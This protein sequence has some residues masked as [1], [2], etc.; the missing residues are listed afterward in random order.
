[1]SILLT[2][3]RINELFSIFVTQAKGAAATGKTDFNKVME[4]VL[5]PLFEIVYGC[6]NLKNLNVEKINYPGIDLG[7]EKARIAFQIT[8]TAD[9]EKVKDTLKKF[10]KYELYKKY[11]RLIIYIITEKQKISSD[12]AIKEIIGDKFSFDKEKDVID[13][14]D[15]LKKV[16]AFQ[17]DKTRKIENILEANFGSNAVPI[18]DNN[19]DEQTETV[20]LNL[21]PIIYPEHIYSGE[22]LTEVLKE[23]G[24]ID[25]S[26]LPWE[27]EGKSS[28]EKIWNFMKANGYKFASDWEYYDG[29]IYTF[30][31]LQTESHP[32]FSVLDVGTIEEST[33]E[34]FISLDN[35]YENI[36]KSLLRRCLQRM[37]Y[38]KGVTWQ[39]LENIFI[40]VEENN[41]AKR[42]EQWK[43]KKKNEREV[44]VRIM[45]NNKPK[46]I[47]KCKHF[48][49]HARFYKYSKEWYL[50]ITPDWFFSYDGFNKSLFAEKDLKYLK[51]VENN[52]H[53]ANHLHFIEYFLNNFEK[54]KNFGKSI[55]KFGNFVS[56]NESPSLDD[57]KARLSKEEK[58]DDTSNLSDFEL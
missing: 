6:T 55:L 27:Q 40:F 18:F 37:L 1:M 13:Y 47:L 29:R 16:E 9:I 17:I 11:E 35:Q 42:I 38:S 15:I 20:F 21:L 34:E 57:S 12:N 41:K 54:Q 14:R 45:K 23:S 30:H 43:G 3:Q 10:I 24:T 2:Q 36:F 4:T 7:D 44:Y 53:I 33:T 19:A 25:E 46:E 52:A 22:V 28:R 8:A 39:H 56:F 5:I 58:D 48:G 31:D 50:A 49:F 32:L 51:R 26:Q